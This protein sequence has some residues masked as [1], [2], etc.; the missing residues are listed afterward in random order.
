MEVLEIEYQQE[1]EIL[2]E[3]TLLAHFFELLIPTTRR[4]D[5]IYDL[6]RDKCR[7]LSPA[8]KNITGKNCDEL[9]SRPLPFIKSLAHPIDY[10]AFLS[11]FIEF[12][13]IERDS[14]SQHLN[15]RMRSFI[16][17]VI[18]KK[19]N[20][21]KI[22]IHALYLAPDRVVGIIR[23]HRNNER[24]HHSGKGQV[25]PRE[26]EVLELIASGNS[27]KIIGDKL[28]IS[29]TTVTTHRKHLKQKFNAK[30]TAELIREAVKAMII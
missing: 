11:E 19:G 2:N 8:I 4:P 13:K 14:G 23:K 12:V 18:N 6:K 26:I 24:F 27:A 21:E 1:N 30:N 15:D 22:R 7:Y 10:M 5:F 20:W 3:K 28:N 25:S 9:L 16:F 17:R 29:E